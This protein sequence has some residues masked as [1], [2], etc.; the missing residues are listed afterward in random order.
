MHIEPQDKYVMI[1]YRLDGVLFVNGTTVSKGDAFQSFLQKTGFSPD[2]IIF[3]DDRE[4]NL[5]SLSAAIQKMDK[6]IEFQGLHFLGAQKYPSKIISENEFE[7]RWE[8]L[9]LQAK[10]LD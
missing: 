6:S 3:I 4:E 1:R 9:A 7:S 2:K 10:Q 8:Q 5:K